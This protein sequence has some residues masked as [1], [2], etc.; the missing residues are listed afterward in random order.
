MSA[1]LRIREG[2]PDV[3]GHLRDG[4]YRLFEVYGVGAAWDVSVTANVV[5]RGHLDGRY[6]VFMGQDFG[7]R[8]RDYGL[9]PMQVVSR[10]SDIRDL[11]TDFGL[12]DFA[13]AFLANHSGSDVSVHSV[14]S[15]VY[16]ATRVLGNFDADHVIGDRQRTLY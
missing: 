7:G 9:A 11:R 16:L 4:F 10:L 3:A 2:E 8:P 6:S 14:I 5:L 13:E 15:V 1:T 12:D